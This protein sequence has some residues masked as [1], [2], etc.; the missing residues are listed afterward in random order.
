MDPYNDGG[1]YVSTLIDGA[2]LLR[3]IK[4]N[5]SIHVAVEGNKS[6]QI[7]WSTTEALL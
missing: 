7:H 2:F 6:K 1:R 3:F 4:A 5:R